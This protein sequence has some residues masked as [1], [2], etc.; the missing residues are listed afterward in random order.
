MNPATV[1]DSETNEDLMLARLQATL[2]RFTL[3]ASHC[4]LHIVRFTLY[5]SHCTLHIVR[6]TLYASHC[7]EFLLLMDT[8]KEVSEDGFVRL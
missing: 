8:R 6:F 1:A 2:V 5:A 7:T 4:T 3:Y